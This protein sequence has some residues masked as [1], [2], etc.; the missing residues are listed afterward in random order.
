MVESLHEFVEKTWFCQVDTRE[1]WLLN[2]LTWDPSE[3]MREV[4]ISL[5]VFLGSSARIWS[6]QLYCECVTIWLAIWDIQI[7]YNFY[8]ERQ[9]WFPW[10]NCKYLKSTQEAKMSFILFQCRV[11]KKWSVLDWRIFILYLCMND[12]NCNHSEGK[13]NQLPG[14]GRKS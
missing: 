11:I 13:L 12:Y 5:G 3:A 4:A 8:Q 6:G 14:T 10:L 2:L 9:W 1:Y 7:D